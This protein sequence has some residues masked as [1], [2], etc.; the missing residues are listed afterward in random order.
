M[1]LDSTEEYYIGYR[2]HNPN[3]NS[4]NNIQWYVYV[5]RVRIWYSKCKI[6]LSKPILIILYLFSEDDQGLVNP[7]F[8]QKLDA[9]SRPNSSEMKK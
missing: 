3:Y 9:F 1:D 4:Q 2:I 5:T 8:D 7:I 6:M